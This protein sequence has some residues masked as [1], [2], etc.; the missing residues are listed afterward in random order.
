M[1]LIKDTRITENTKLRFSLQALNA[2]N[3]P[4]FNPPNS[5][6]FTNLS[7]FGVVTNSTQYNYPRRLQLEL[8]FIF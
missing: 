3:H 6:A 1:S 4:L 2:F 5:T 8:K 7:Q